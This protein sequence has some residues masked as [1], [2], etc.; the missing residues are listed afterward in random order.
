LGYSSPTGLCPPKHFGP[1]TLRHTCVTTV[2][3]WNL[4]GRQCL[5]TALWQ[6]SPNHW[7]MLQVSLHRCRHHLRFR[8]QQHPKHLWP[9]QGMVATISGPF[10][11]YPWTCLSLSHTMVRYLSI[12]M[13]R[14]RAVVVVRPKTRRKVDRT[15]ASLR[16][17]ST[18]SPV[19]LG[20]PHPPPLCSQQMV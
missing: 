18:V 10:P 1:A 17:L 14:C 13:C 8:R 9:S 15:S 7:R 12:L 20:F 2:W 5:R 11:L 6:C 16:L 4:T 3:A 19:P